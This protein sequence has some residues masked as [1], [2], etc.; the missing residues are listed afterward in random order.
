MLKIF[1]I[2]V[3]MAGLF[4]GP[5]SSAAETKTELGL[6]EAIVAGTP[7]VLFRY[8]Y[9]FVDDDNFDNDANASTLRLRLNY[10]TG[11]WRAWSGFAEF[12]YIAH[13]LQK[14]FNSLGGTS[15]GKEGIYPV[16]ADPE[17][18]DLNQFYLDYEGFADTRL[19]FGRQR[20]LL[21]NQRFIGPVGWRQNEQTYDGVSLTFKGLA[22]TEVFYSYVAQVNRIL[23]ERSPAGQDDANN[24]TLN[25]R[26]SFSDKWKLTPYYY[27]IDSEDSP[28]FS[29]STL[30]AR[31]NGTLAIGDGT[32]K[33]V[34]EAA[35]QSEAA[36]N[37]ADYDAEYYHLSANWAMKNGLSLGLGFESLGGED[38]PIGEAFRTP[39]ATLHAFQGWAD[40]FLATGAG[41]PGAGVE[42]F[43]ASVKYKMQKWNLQAIYHDFSAADGSAT[44]G[45]EF[46]LAASRSLGDRYAILLKAA[47]FSADDPNFRDVTKLWLQLTAKY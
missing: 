2:A 29:T 30:G 35:T 34:G 16:V 42:D 47:F 28:V 36:D 4:L 5:L 44:W 41:N 46:D 11:K 32:L 25:V 8:R 10:K 43:Y 38:S 12:D 17:G 33:L 7:H 37:P 20:I 39:L 27:Y 9:E 31:L 13:L 24:H 1:M 3:G 40:Q 26:I 19:R 22:K 15:P 6:G 18:A 45:S 21:D 14:D 23:G